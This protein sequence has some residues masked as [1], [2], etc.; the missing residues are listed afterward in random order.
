MS[1]IGTRPNRIVANIFNIMEDNNVRSDETKKLEEDLREHQSEGEELQKKL[2][3]SRASD[4]EKKAD[5]L[6][7]SQE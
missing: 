4:Y 1:K 3:E 6:R 7:E 2:D 5:E